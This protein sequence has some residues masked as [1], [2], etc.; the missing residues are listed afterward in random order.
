MYKSFVSNTVQ[1]QH[2][3]IIFQRE[4][5]FLELTVFSLRSKLKSAKNVMEVAAQMH[6]FDYFVNVHK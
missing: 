1:Q 5:A 3:R 2:Q 6:A 4:G